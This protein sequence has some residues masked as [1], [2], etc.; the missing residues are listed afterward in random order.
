MNHGIHRML[1][2]NLIIL[3]GLSVVRGAEPDGTG[4]AVSE[5]TFRLA[6]AGPAGVDLQ[7]ELERL[8]RTETVISGKRF[9]RFR[10]ADAS[11]SG[12]EGE[13][14]LPAVVRFVLIPPRSGV[15]LKITR[16]ETRLERDVRPVPYR[17]DAGNDDL[18]AEFELRTSPDGFWPPE[19]ARLGT[20]AI[21]RGYRIVPV[22]VHPL[23][24][25]PRTRQ[26]KVIESIEMKLDFDSPENRVNLVENPQRPRPSSA[27]FNIV[28]RLVM[29]PPPPPRDMG[30]RNGS[31]AYVMGDW[32]NVEEEL[33]PL[34]EWRRRKGWTVEVIRV[35]QNNSNVAIKNAI[36]EAYDEWDTP[37]ELIVICGDTDGQFPM[38]FW[39]ERH[40]AGYP[41]ETDH[42][43]TELEGRDVLPE[44]AVGRL[45]FN[46]INMLRG[47]VN[48]TVR[49]ESDPYIGNGD[50]RNWQKRATLVSGDSRSGLS[51][52]D[53]CRW[54]KD[55]ALRHG[56][57]EVAELYWTPQNP[58]PN[59]QQ[60]ILHNIDAGCSV[61][62]YRGWTFMNNFRFEDVDRLRN[63]RM[64][65]FAM[66]ATC[67][68]GDFG[69]HVSSPFYYTERFLY[70][71]SG[72]A[73]GA[74]GAAGAT[75]T[76]YNNLL[77]ASTIK[78][79]LADGLCNQGWALMQGKIDLYR[80]YA[81]YDDIHHH[82]NPGLE[83]WLCELYIF[84][85]MGDPGVDLYTD[86]PT[87]L[88]VDHPDRIR[89]GETHFEVRVS[90]PDRDQPVEDVRVCLYK[91][92]EFQLVA[93]TDA[94]GRTEFDLDPE[95][96]QDGEILLTVT[97]HNL[98]PLLEEFE[99]GE[100]QRFIGAGAFT[101]DDD[102]EGESRGDG[103]GAAN[104]TERI[105]LAVQIVNYGTQLP[106]GEMT[107]ALTPGAPML[108]VVEGQARFDS[109]PDVGDALE[110]NFVI[111]IGGGFPQGEQAVFD[112]ECAVGD[113]SWHS[114]VA[115]PVEG[116]GFEFA[117]LL[118]DGKPPSISAIRK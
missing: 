104:P 99:V 10:F 78:A 40:G 12:T 34:I 30:T 41:Y 17:L 61:F 64:L 8:S 5:Y 50:D 37:P 112:L 67:N 21:M 75:H 92:G 87:E 101:V 32:D 90:Q 33:E 52:I 31:I 103:D 13:P 11:P 39:D 73:I 6:N 83:A 88:D 68:T 2:I 111:D 26:L 115:V 76:A 9:D 114:S 44:A 91:P 4:V 54:T 51:S 15:E 18:Q 71:R 57:T 22:I 1:F 59:A 63:G 23:R 27:V 89:V 14:D 96:T 106:R 35:R 19:T 100:A 86:V 98:M 107:A 7:F 38:A 66:L 47:I 70:N 116:P 108:E 94:E 28:S 97:G 49:Y 3:L 46:S 42:H 74:V 93:Y 79:F 43:Y 95:W 55:L 117:S 58:R 56:F 25:N 77:A 24:W 16:L 69:E 36:Q 85:L 81:D 72:G 53:V 84:N 20:P 105:E 102:D 45:I 65:P 118:W 110:A 82:E 48:K 62:L 113:E 29:N 109:A 80:H 60:F